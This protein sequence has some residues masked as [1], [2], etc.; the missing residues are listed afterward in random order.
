MQKP[1]LTGRPCCLLHEHDDKDIPVLNATTSV[2]GKKSP[3]DALYKQLQAKMG[4]KK[5]LGENV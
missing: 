3:V 1:E 5:I 4:T 2:E